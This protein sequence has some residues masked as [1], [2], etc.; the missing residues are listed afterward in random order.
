MTLL[1]QIASRAQKELKRIPWPASLLKEPRQRLRR[2]GEARLPLTRHAV[3][4]AY[5]R[6]LRLAERVLAVDFEA[7]VPFDSLVRP[8]DLNLIDPRGGA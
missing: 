4:L 5:G 1:L 6:P 3:N 7:G 8:A 2:R